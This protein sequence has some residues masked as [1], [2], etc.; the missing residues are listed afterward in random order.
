MCFSGDE[1]RQ[2]GKTLDRWQDRWGGVSGREAE[3]E[4]REREMQRRRMTETEREERKGMSV[5]GGGVAC[6]ISPSLFSTLLLS[7]P[8]PVSLF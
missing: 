2:R 8:L 1:E 3:T 5:K 7:V 4:D 6:L